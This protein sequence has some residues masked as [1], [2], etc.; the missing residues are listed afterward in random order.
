VETEFSY[1]EEVKLS[2][3]EGIALDAIFVKID[4][5]PSTG[6]VIIYGWGRDGNLKGIGIRGPMER[7]DLPFVHPQIFVRYDD[8]ESFQLSTLGWAQSRGTRFVPP[9]LPSPT[10]GIRH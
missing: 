5:K 2:V 10:H 7:V 1:N 6:S 9:N 4:M 3:P 8:V